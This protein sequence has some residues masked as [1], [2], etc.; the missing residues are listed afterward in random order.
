MHAEM[1]ADAMDALRDENENLRNQVATMLFD[2][3]CEEK[4]EYLDR[5]NF[6]TADNKRLEIM[7]RGLIEARNR[8]M[9][10]N[11]SLRKQG[12]YAARKLKALEKRAS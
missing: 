4:A 5:L 11:V 7:N 2:G 10:E 1:L 9:L 12:E 8:V 3:T 6:L